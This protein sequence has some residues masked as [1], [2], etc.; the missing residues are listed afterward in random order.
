MKGIDTIKNWVGALTE[1]GLMFLALAIVLGLLVGGNLPFFGAVTTNI[2]TWVKDLGAN[3][4]VGL[5]T[6]GIV[7]WLFSTRQLSGRHSGTDEVSGGGRVRLP[8]TLYAA[9]VRG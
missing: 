5:M 3:G 7:L 9:S 4:L 6:L 1:L 8:T 2:V